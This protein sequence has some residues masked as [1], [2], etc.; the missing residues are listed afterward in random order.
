MTLEEI[1]QFAIGAK[2]FI[3][4]G[5]AQHDPELSSPERNVIDLVS[6]LSV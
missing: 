2:F 6:N 3:E 1:N 4:D 5:I